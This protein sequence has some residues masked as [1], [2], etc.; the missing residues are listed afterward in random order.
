MQKEIQKELKRTGLSL[1]ELGHLLAKDHRTEFD[2]ALIRALLDNERLQSFPEAWTDVLAILTVLPDGVTK[3]GKKYSYSKDRIFLT[4][5]MTDHINAEFE[6]TRVGPRD[7]ARRVSD[8]ASFETLHKRIFG[9]K[10]GAV[11]TIPKSDWQNVISYLAGLPDAVFVPDPHR[12]R[13]VPKLADEAVK[14]RAKINKPPPADKKETITNTD[15]SKAEP[16]L[17][18]ERIQP[19]RQRPNLDN[20][21]LSD[22]RKLLGYIVIDELQYQKLHNERMRT[23]VSSRRLVASAPDAPAGIDSRTIDNWFLGRII[24]AEKEHLEWVLSAYA[25]LPSI[26]DC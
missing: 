10:N 21:H 20:H 1:R 17:T 4:P 11:K 5:E 25:K 18:P 15:D 13:E 26:D 23:L 12:K 6:R 8:K 9:W 24:S 16:D 3:Q 19:A 2:P 14:R 7:V 22:N